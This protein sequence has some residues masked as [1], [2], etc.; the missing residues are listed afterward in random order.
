MWSFKNPEEARPLEHLL[1]RPFDSNLLAIDHL[2]K[3]D[4]LAITME[5]K[6]CHRR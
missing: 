2:R 6:R 3:T 1:W 5:R 4:D